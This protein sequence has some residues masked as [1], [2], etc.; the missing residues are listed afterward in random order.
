[1]PGK[2]TRLHTQKKVPLKDKTKKRGETKKLPKGR[3][4]AFVK[5]GI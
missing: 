3:V 4:L 1:M 5:E 2:G